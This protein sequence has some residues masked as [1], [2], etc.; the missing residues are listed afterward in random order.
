[1]K[2]NTAKYQKSRKLIHLELLRIIAV[3]LVLF[4]HTGQKGFL[5]FAESRGLP[6]YS[7]YLFISII[8]KIAVPIFFHD[9]WCVVVEK[10]RTNLCH[11]SKKSIKNIDR[12]IIDIFYPICFR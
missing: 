9:L 1:M 5:Y 7:I 2:Y 8:D 10:G 6:M 4:N 12:F 11:I 3:F